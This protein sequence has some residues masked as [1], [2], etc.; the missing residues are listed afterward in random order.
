MG[1]GGKFKGDGGLDGGG[2]F[3][4][5]LWKRITTHLEEF[6]EKP[7]DFPTAWSLSISDWHKAVAFE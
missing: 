2:K 5:R 4:P 3:I 6:M 7:H 1:D